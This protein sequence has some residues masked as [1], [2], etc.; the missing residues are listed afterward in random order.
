MSVQPPVGATLRLTPRQRLLNAL[1]G[2]AVDR[3][4][5]WMMRQAGRYLPEYQSVRRRYDFLE[6]CKT[7]KAAA[8]VSVQPVEIVGSDAV[9]IFN[10]ILIP[11]EAA[12][13]KVEFG[14]AGPR[15][16][17]PVRTAKELA[18]LGE[19]EITSG[20]PVVGTIE[21]VRE[22]VGPDFPVLGFCG[23]PWTLA[24]YWIEGVMTRNFESILTMRWR[25][26]A[27]LEA[28]LERITLYAA[29][30]LKIQIEAGADA[31][32]IFD[33]WGSVLGQ[34]DYERFSGRWIRK[35]ID[36]VRGLGA[37]VIVY[38]NGVAPYLET[39]GGLGADCVSID[40]RIELGEA[41]RRLGEG[42]ALQGNLDPLVLYAGPEVV[43]REV[44]KLFQRFPPQAGH[45]F[46]LGHGVLPKTPVQSAKRLFEAVK[47]YG[48]C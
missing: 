16:T 3:V 27:L 23:A 7:P 9:I 22:K 36:E 48:A 45:V 18:A 32:Q 24:S 35:I 8:E 25:E 42:V 34:N 20:E 40:W 4:P 13:A 26:P 15:I 46:N 14:E 44:E 30:Y 29:R 5:A 38:V 10:D 11:L 43:E 33:T 12:G 41:R 2:E 28:I 39:L 6:L 19:G 17:N 1:R 31:V 37:P 47:R 21:A